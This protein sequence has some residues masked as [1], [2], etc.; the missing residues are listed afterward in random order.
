MEP[1]NSLAPRFALGKALGR[2][3]CCGSRFGAGIGL[4]TAL[5]FYFA[6]KAEYGVDGKPLTFQ[7]ALIRRMPG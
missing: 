3:H 4:L 6:W 1:W 2:A 5:Q 7:D